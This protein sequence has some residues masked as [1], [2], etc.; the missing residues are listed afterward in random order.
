MLCFDD[1]QNHDEN[2]IHVIKK[3]LKHQNGILIITVFRDLYIEKPLFE[4][5]KAPPKE[6]IVRQTMIEYE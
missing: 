4:D 5:P 2:T 3:L 1:A 6:D